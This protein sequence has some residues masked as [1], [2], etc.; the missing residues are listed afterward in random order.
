MHV[1]KS[2]IW[3]KQLSDAILSLIN[4]IYKLEWSR[5]HP[6]PDIVDS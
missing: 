1:N 2:N 3:K 5:Y 6:Q 4:K